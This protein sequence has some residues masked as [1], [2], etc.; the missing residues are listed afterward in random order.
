MYYFFPLSKGYMYIFREEVDKLFAQ[1]T[2]V[3]NK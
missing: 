2:R 1:I 3:H